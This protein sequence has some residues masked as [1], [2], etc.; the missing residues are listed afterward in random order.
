MLKKL[1]NAAN[2]S[3]FLY[4]S[5]RKQDPASA[6]SQVLSLEVKWEP[7]SQNLSDLNNRMKRRTDGKCVKHIPLF[8]IDLRCYI[9]GGCLPSHANTK[10]Q[11][12]DVHLRSKMLQAW[13][14]DISNVT[15]FIDYIIIIS[16][17]ANIICGYNI[18]EI[19]K[20]V[21][22]TIC[23]HVLARQTRGLKTS[24]LNLDFIIKAQQ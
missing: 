15:F 19:E 9:T 1:Y 10:Y 18:C 8:T 13:I 16:S 4:I 22:P 7:S 23:I 24:E 12:L 6:W 2:L 20:Q 3:Y 14:A 21:D 17:L 5:Q 11:R